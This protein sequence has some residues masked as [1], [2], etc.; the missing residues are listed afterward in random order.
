MMRPECSV[1]A[2]QEERV[3][4]LTSLALF[5]L[6]FEP[7][8]EFLVRIKV[9][10]FV[11]AQRSCTAFSKVGKEFPESPLDFSFHADVLQHSIHEVLTILLGFVENSFLVPLRH[12]RQNCGEQHV[13]SVGLQFYSFEGLPRIRVRTFPVVESNGV[14]RRS[15]GGKTW[16]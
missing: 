16:E 8:V 13:G 4:S 9:Q 7:I 12:D 14:P 5:L 10:V 3:V 1:E 2:F 6:L 15:R 11:D